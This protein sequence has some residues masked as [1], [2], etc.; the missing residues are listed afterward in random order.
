VPLTSRDIQVWKNPVTMALHFQVHPCGVSEIF[1][2]AVPASKSKEGALYPDGAH[3][4][5][6]ADVR[7]ILY[8]MQRPGIAP[9]VSAA[10]DYMLLLH[11][12]P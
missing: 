12:T 11:L 4:T 3:L 6:L 5:D 7:G 1:V 8:E 10:C 9:D 2:D